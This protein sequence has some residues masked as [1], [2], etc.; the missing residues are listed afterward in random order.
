LNRHL[1]KL[2]D[3][4]LKGRLKEYLK[5]ARKDGMSYRTIAQELSGYGTPVGRTAVENWCKEMKLK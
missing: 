2:K 3:Y 4:E 1:Y 5:Q